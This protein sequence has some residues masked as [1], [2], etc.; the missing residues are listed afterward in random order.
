[1][2][3]FTQD[4]CVDHRCPDIR[5][6]QQF[7]DSTDVIAGLHEVSRETVA[8]CV[9]RGSLGNT[10]APERVRKAAAEYRRMEASLAKIRRVGRIA[11]RHLARLRL[12]LERP[13]SP[14]R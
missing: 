2:A 10:G 12:R 9:S 14:Y 3:S 5:V 13:T 6:T 4:V 8:Q 11:A 7:L 1:M